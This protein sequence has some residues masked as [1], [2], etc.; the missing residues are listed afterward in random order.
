M[1]T[2]LSFLS[3][4]HHANVQTSSGDFIKAI[5]TISANA[6]Q[7]DQSC[8]GPNSL[9]RQ[10]VSA[11]C[12]ES[13]MKSMLQGG[14]PLTVGVGIIIEVIRKNNS[15]YDPAGINGPGTIPSTYDPI[16]LGT[17]LRQF[18]EHI[19]DFMALLRS[20]KHTVNDCGRVK[21]VERVD[22]TSPWGAKVE[23]LG[24][25][26]F[27]T[28]ELM[29]ELLHCSN[30]G[31]LNSA[32]SEDYIQQRD[33]ER[34]QLVR[35]GTLNMHGEGFSGVDFNDSSAD[36]VNGSS[37]LGSGSPKDMK[38]LEV[39]DA[40]EEEGFEDVS[41]PGVLV[42]KEQDNT[43]KDARGQESK[44]EPVQGSTQGDES[45]PGDASQKPTLSE[46]VGP[47]DLKSPAS[48][49]SDQMGGIKLGSEQGSKESPAETQKPATPDA[50]ESAS[51]NKESAP[52]PMFSH[53]EDV[54]APLFAAKPSTEPSTTSHFDP[55]AEKDQSQPTE[56]A[57][58]P[59]LQPFIQVDVN[60]QPVV[61][62]Y[63]KIM[64]IENRVV[65]TIL[66]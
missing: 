46:A 25:D 37:M 35:D 7:N 12:V 65:P 55:A 23:P 51:K 11:P 1:P 22:L 31:L 4:E 56:G 61:G 60:G 2:L 29:A 59:R 18:A 6:I 63:L 66:V 17:L 48:G 50:Q 58:N 45:K 47:S 15:D 40:G 32:G 13:L 8:I 49:L 62:D 41:P 53:P 24:F 30:M 5:I 52:A 19:P 26:R 57:Q 36:F 16:Y 44:N 54:P 43:D 38:S 28:C 33:A 27:K 9:T 3:P 21:R 14:N 42:N 34:E 64:F 10:L 20:S 39:T